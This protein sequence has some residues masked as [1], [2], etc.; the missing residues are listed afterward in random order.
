[1]NINLTFYYKNEI[2]KE[3]LS[4][5]DQLEYLIASLQLWITLISEIYTKYNISE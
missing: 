5:A 1:M 4:R 3:L 2:Y